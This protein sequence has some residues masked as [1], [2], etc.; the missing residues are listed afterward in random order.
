MTYTVYIFDTLLVSFN[1]ENVDKQVL[2][3]FGTVE[4]ITQTQ[5]FH[6]VV[7]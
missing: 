7:S 1:K 6:K 3:F 5:G 2:Y 4:Q